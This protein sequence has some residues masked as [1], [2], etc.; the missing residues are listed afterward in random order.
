M[1][2]A[3]ISSYG[4]YCGIARY[5]YH[6][7]E[8]LLKKGCE[9]MI[10]ARY[11]EKGEYYEKDLKK[12]PVRMVRCWGGDN[13]NT[14][15]IKKELLKYNPDI[16]HVQDICRIEKVYKDIHKLFPGK[17]VITL[18]S[19]GAPRATFHKVKKISDKTFVN[20]VKSYINHYIVHNELSKKYLIEK[21][22]ID[23]ENISVIDHGTLCCEKISQKEARKKLKLPKNKAII[24]TYGFFGLKKGIQEVISVLPNISK[25]IPNIY[26]IHVGRKRLGGK[27]KHYQTY[28]EIKKEIQKK[29][30]K[31]MVKFIWKYC[32]E[33]E[34][35][36][37][38]RAADLIII[39]YPKKD[40]LLH[41]SGVAH[42]IISCQRPVIASKVS[43]F[44]EF[45]ESSMY[46][47]PHNLKSL[48]KAILK[49]L[50]DKNL[51]KKL[52]ENALRYSKASSWKKTAEKHLIAFKKTIK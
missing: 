12:L 23:K 13:D 3:I 11:K 35:Q 31:N 37:Y 10:F 52:A 43:T 25:K 24:L 2:I 30:L 47:I 42:Q 29:G 51:Q 36:L 32:S 41:A 6:L 44:S 5:T 46:K 1:K 50:G 39:F 19:V 14:K 45:P 49:V 40:P 26:Y 20:R 34:A 21:N 15:K 48:E 8:A 18:H 22:K 28:Q 17:I 38:Y 27:D 7:V 33:K 4:V 16:I 9:V